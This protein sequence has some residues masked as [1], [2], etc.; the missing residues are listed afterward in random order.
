M[1]TAVIKRGFSDIADNLTIGK[2]LMLLAFFGLAAYPPARGVM[3]RALSD[4]YFQVAVFVAATLFGMFLFERARRRDLHAMLKKHENMQVLFAAICGAIPGCGGAIFVVTQYIRGAI[5]FGGVVATLTA[6]MGDA[7][8]LLL[9]KSPADAAIVFSV[10][11]VMGV[12]FGYLVDMIHGRDFLR[13][14]LDETDEEEQIRENPLLAPAYL[15]WLVLFLPG[16]AVGIAYAAQVD[17]ANALQVYGVNWVETFGATAA[18]LA[19]IMWT[20]NPLSD[21]RLCTSPRR[22][23]A[24]RTVDTTNFITVWVLC[25]FVAYGLLAEIFQINLAAFFGAWIWFAP[26]AAVIIGFIPGCGPQIVVTTLFLNGAIPLSAQLAN[27]ISNDGDALF[28]AVAVAPKASIIATLYTAV[29]ALI[30][31]YGWMI[32]LE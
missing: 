29:P 5:S 20:L 24:R 23:I 26:L 17:V 19:I 3:L 27:A 7:A 8:F 15:L 2:P 1:N 16:A 12:L 30:I 13:F 25:G 10:C 4:A 28:P 31:G 14:K 9:V 32:F 11:L 6:T 21:I 18:A 22:T